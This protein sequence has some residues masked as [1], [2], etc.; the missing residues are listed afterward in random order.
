[1]LRALGV[2]IL[3]SLVAGCASALY[4]WNIQHAYVAPHAHLSSTETE[5]II[6]TVTAK[7]LSVIIGMSRFSERGKPDQVTVYTELDPSSSLMMVYDLEKGQDGSW[8]IVS[9]GEGT[10]IVY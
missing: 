3:S 8:R 1:M 7:S 6:R 5:Q 10:I 2:F 9:W 4:D